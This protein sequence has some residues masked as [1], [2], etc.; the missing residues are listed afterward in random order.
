VVSEPTVPSSEDEARAKEERALLARIARGAPEAN[1]AM[2]TLF[3]RYQPRFRSHL[4]SRGFRDGDIDDATQ[5]VWSDVARKAGKFSADGV[6]GAWL[7]GFF[8]IAK[9]DVIRANAQRGDRFVSAND[10]R[11]TSPSEQPSTESNAPSPEAQRSARDF[12]DCV[13]RAFAAFKRQHSNEAWWVYLR[14]VEEWDLDQIAE[15]RGS[16]SHAAA[17]FLSQARKG[18]RELLAPCRDLKPD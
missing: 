7:W 5:R 18:F 1:S 2:R 13:Q 17:Q 6:P 15:Y 12:N 10:D 16:S 11:Q 8:D 14:H 4:R 9:K 3:N